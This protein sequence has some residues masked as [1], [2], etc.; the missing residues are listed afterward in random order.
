M[1]YQVL[2]SFIDEET[3][4]GYN[5]GSTFTSLDAERVSFLSQHGFIQSP[6]IV[7]PKNEITLSDIKAK[8]KSLK[9][10]GYTSMEK[11]ELLAA[12]E[13]AERAND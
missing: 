7:S 12:I 6:V 2:V 5:A 8:A 1:Y 3:G 10:K 13:V 4:E 11:D 9:I